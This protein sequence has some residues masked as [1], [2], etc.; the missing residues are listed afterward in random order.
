MTLVREV[1]LEAQGSGLERG[2]LM[3]SN[4]IQGAPSV[5]SVAIRVCAV[6]THYSR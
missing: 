4:T 5:N 3:Q 6:L 1:R 2:K